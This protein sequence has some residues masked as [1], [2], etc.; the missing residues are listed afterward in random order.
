MCAYHSMC[1]IVREDHVWEWVLSFYHV[2]SGD[3]AQAIKFGDK[4]LYPPSHL[5]S[6]NLSSFS[7]WKVPVHQWCYSYEIILSI[8]YSY[9]ATN[10]AT[11]SLEALNPVSYSFIFNLLFTIWMSYSHSSLYSN[12]VKL[13]IELVNLIISI[14]T[15]DTTGY[16]V[17][18]NPQ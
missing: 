12:K 15:N 2:C 8:Y 6:L 13:M 4:C 3:W 1:M 18:K 9:Y 14:L 17:G 10:L 11:S 5:D 7:R 16:S